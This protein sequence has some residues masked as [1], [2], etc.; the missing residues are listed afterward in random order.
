VRRL[1]QDREYQRKVKKGQARQNGGVTGGDNP[2][3]SGGNQKGRGGTGEGWKRKRE[4]QAVELKSWMEEHK[5][6]E[7]F[8]GEERQ[9]KRWTLV[10]GQRKGS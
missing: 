2:S 6:A 8:R 1:F 4:I 5:E 9:R 3:Q 10:G 7:G